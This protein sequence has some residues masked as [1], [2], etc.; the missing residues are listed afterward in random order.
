[1]TRR[2]HSLASAALAALLSACG[3]G[4]ACRDPPGYRLDGED[5]IGAVG[6][7]KPGR[8]WLSKALD[9]RQRD[10]LACLFAG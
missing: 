7:A 4:W 6:V 9:E 1:M 5:P 10:D 3:A 8:V 2:Q